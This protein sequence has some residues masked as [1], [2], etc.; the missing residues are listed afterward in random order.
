[1]T[2]KIKFQNNQTNISITFG[3]FKK[4]QSLDLDLDL[5]RFNF[6]PDSAGGREI[7][8][9]DTI[10]VDVFSISVLSLRKTWFLLLLVFESPWI[11]QEV[12]LILGR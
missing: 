12:I 10:G 8:N 7:T 5:L 9:K 3:R 1:M 6:P 4:I 11:R 2:G